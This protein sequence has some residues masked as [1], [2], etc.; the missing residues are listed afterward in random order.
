VCFR[1]Y[2]EAAYNEMALTPEPEIMRVGLTSSMLQLKCLGQ[3]LEDLD[4]M[5][6]PDRDS[7]EHVIFCAMS[8]KC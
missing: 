2:T 8:R 1:L 5:D 3:D 7:S 6:L 4:L